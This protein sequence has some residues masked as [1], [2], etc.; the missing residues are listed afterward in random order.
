MF[1]VYR[2]STKLRGYNF[3]SLAPLELKYWKCR[4][5]ERKYVFFSTLKLYALRHKFNNTTTFIHMLLHCY[6]RMGVHVGK[7]NLK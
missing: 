2:F 3:D 1:A 6:S 7:T 4:F 5:V